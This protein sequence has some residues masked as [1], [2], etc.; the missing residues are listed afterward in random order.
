MNIRRTISIV[1]LTAFVTSSVK[2]PAYA[3]MAVDPMPHMSVPGTMVHLS[4]EFTPAYLKAIVIHPENALQFDFIIDKGDKVLTDAQQRV[5][6]TKLTKYFLA[7][8]AI[9]DDDQW[10]NLS[11][12]E[13]DRIIK[14][15][16]GKTEMGRDLLAQDYMLK[17]ITAS[18]V[19]PE[20]NLGKKF[21]DKIYS[22]AQEQFGTT[23][24]PVN[25]F[26][27]VWILPD[28][29]LIYEKGNIAYVI[30]NHLRVMLEEDY[31]ALKNHTGIQS[32]P[33]DNKTHTIASRI[34]K[35]IVLPE[36]ER[37]VNE[38]ENFATVRQVY[39]GM[40]LATWY[41]RALKESLLSKIYANQSK[42][43]GVDQDPRTNE[44]IYHQYL[45]AY[46]KGVFNFIKEDV[47]KYSNEMIPRKYFSGG[48]VSYTTG[49]EMGL[50]HYQV[51]GA[52]TPV[53][54]EEIVAGIP[55]DVQVTIRAAESLS[56]ARTVAS[57]LTPAAGGGGNRITPPTG[58]G[59]I[60]SLE[61]LQTRM[62]ESA[63][64]ELTNAVQG[65]PI[66]DLS[67]MDFTP[68]GNAALQALVQNEAPDTHSP[69]AYVEAGEFV[70]GHE[71]GDVTEDAILDD[72]ADSFE[73]KCNACVIPVAF[74]NPGLAT[75]VITYNF[76]SKY[77]Q[78]AKKAVNPNVFNLTAFNNALSS[79]VSSLHLDQVNT[80]VAPQDVPR[81]QAWVANL[82]PQLQGIM[83]RLFSNKGSDASMLINDPFNDFRNTNSFESTD[84]FINARVGHLE[85]GSSRVIK[86]EVDGDSTTLRM[87]YDGLNDL[88]SSSGYAFRLS[89]TE[90]KTAQDIDEQGVSIVDVTITR[91]P[92]FKGF[93]ARKR[94][95]V[96][97][98]VD[99]KRYSS[100]QVS[101]AISQMHTNSYASKPAEA[102]RS[103]ILDSILPTQLSLI[104]S[105]VAGM[106][107]DFGARIEGEKLTVDESKVDQV[108]LWLQ[109]AQQAADSAMTSADIIVK[110]ATPGMYIPE[111]SSRPGTPKEDQFT[112][113]NLDAM[114]VGVD[115]QKT[116]LLYGEIPAISGEEA[117]QEENLIH[118][119]RT[120]TGFIV[121]LEDSA[122]SPSGLSEALILKDKLAGELRTT[123]SLP[124]PIAEQLVGRNNIEMLR[125]DDVELDNPEKQSIG[126]NEFFTRMLQD[127]ENDEFREENKVYLASLNDH[128]VYLT[129]N[130][131][132]VEELKQQWEASVNE[133]SY[134]Y[135][136][137]Q[138]EDQPESRYL[139]GLARASRERYNMPVLGA[140]H[141][142]LVV[143]LNGK[144]VDLAMMGNENNDNRKKYADL[145]KIVE[146]DIGSEQWAD[147]SQIL[148]A[149]G[150]RNIDPKILHLATAPAEDLMPKIDISKGLA[151][152]KKFRDE[153]GVQ[154]VD[155]SDLLRPEFT[156]GAINDAPLL[157]E[158]L[159]KY[160]EPLKYELQAAEP[161]ESERYFITQV[162]HTKEFTGGHV[163]MVMTTT[164]STELG[165]LARV[166]SV[167]T[168]PINPRAIVAAAREKV[169]QAVNAALKVI[170][171]DRSMTI[172]LRPMIGGERSF[173]SSGLVKRT[174]EYL[175]EQQED[176]VNLNPTDYLSR[177]HLADD[178]ARS[179]L[180]SHPVD[181]LSSA[182]DV[183]DIIEHSLSFTE[184]ELIHPVTGEHWM[185]LRQPQNIT[186]TYEPPAEVLRRQVESISPQV[187][188]VTQPAA[189]FLYS[190]TFTTTEYLDNPTRTIWRQVVDWAKANGLRLT[191]LAA[192]GL[193]SQGDA[194]ANTT[195]ADLLANN[196][197]TYHSP[198]SI[199][200]QASLNAKGGIDFNAANLNLQ[201]RRDG[202][203]VPLPIDQQD[204]QNINIDGLI[205][206]II[207]I[208]PAAAS[209]LLSQL[210]LSGA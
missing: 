124:Q 182:E 15:D 189:F 5:E 143:Y 199:D 149:D 107:E 127:R 87:L 121:V 39:S 13:K 57:A 14:D 38:D 172:Q 9:P 45:R 138:D 21:W 77:I 118:V 144:K 36:L 145:M 190:R 176:G 40:L 129:D 22:E 166:W 20:D 198:N 134:F 116:F 152:I 2:A 28:D 79:L 17:Q 188:I 186:M 157:D 139:R 106:P 151:M 193:M 54:G 31:L 75:R 80:S 92:E 161:P 46:K 90:A 156:S 53:E 136:L 94:Q 64:R 29:A 55:R 30:K 112:Q 69:E 154:A 165:P 196:S 63:L 34:V 60:Y 113:E 23:S 12:Y 89:N 174:F 204:L 150:L 137:H 141:G 72:V 169:K 163:M 4:P 41:K 91:L 103:V 33:M 52:A 111:L 26:N 58:T 135:A 96:I 119:T 187:M 1:I 88:L 8:L 68:K 24:I 6:Y 66:T 110:F 177:S 164:T 71:T 210:Q 82:K 51:E 98:T 47:D 117:R 162:V 122:S 159:I 37:E 100:V 173:V 202:K 102:G 74:K 16:F 35:E 184:G 140:L 180:A 42:V 126:I 123:V 67:T 206:V 183:R 197:P 146:Y 104:P 179:Y 99:G 84:S 11:P 168:Q 158:K 7:S 93:N 86:Y 125:D 65:K 130:I 10:V 114:G 132:T 207:R 171:R 49:Q 185:T 19:Y 32:A 62:Q 43:K 192:I 128:L 48:A 200:V 205:P 167:L 194:R 170:G 27:K 209:P 44:Q 195:Q 142:Q 181:A 97:E 133:G 109:Q 160:P 175:Q 76:I 131:K 178:L 95:G 191:A 59:T 61:Q 3:Q 208:R 81:A 201:I 115:N 85:I 70:R 50:T 101:R 147:V 155:V 73:T 153:N 148:R 18:L 56:E 120:P 108:R 83:Q 105:L 25:T 203:G 78:N